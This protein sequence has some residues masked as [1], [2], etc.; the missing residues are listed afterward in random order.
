MCACVSVHVCMPTHMSREPTELGSRAGVPTSEPSI[1][2]RQL[3]IVY[4]FSSRQTE[5]VF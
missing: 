3:T 2:N 1:C 5:D 4:S